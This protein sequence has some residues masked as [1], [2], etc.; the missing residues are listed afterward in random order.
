MHRELGQ[1]VHQ[2][3]A[4]ASAVHN[5]KGVAHGAQLGLGSA[6][7]RRNDQQ[8][9]PHLGAQRLRELLRDIVLREGRQRGDEPVLAF[10]N[11]GRARQDVHGALPDV[12]PLPVPDVLLADQTLAQLG[13]PQLGHQQAALAS[14]HGE[15][16]PPHVVAAQLL[17]RLSN[18]ETLQRAPR[19]KEVVDPLRHRSPAN[20]CAV[21][22][23]AQL[24][25][26]QRLL[27]ILEDRLR[28]AVRGGRS[29]QA[30][31]GSVPRDAALHHTPLL[32]E[33]VGRGAR[34]LQLPQVERRHLIERCCLAA[35]TPAGSRNAGR[36][37]A[38]H[39][40]RLR[41]AAAAACGAA[42]ASAGGLRGLR[43]LRSLR[44]LLGRGARL[45][46]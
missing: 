19:Q 5:R 46:V 11:A 33:V 35:P 15:V 6:L 1:Q 37:L 29:L 3:P 40:R 17:G 26:L 38:R 45:L 16:Q 30:C 12:L 7:G 23:N 42:V 2:E 13:R 9:L 41:A 18:Q 21:E 20:P 43:L 4:V 27:S 24:D 31:V 25:D 34:L 39:K 36:R 28:V 44:L 14:A 32:V 10:G 22:L 8:E